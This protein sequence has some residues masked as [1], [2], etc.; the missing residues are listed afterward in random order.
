MSS[1]VGVAIVGSGIFAR[2]QH[3]PAVQETVD[4]QLKAIYSR[5][6]K[7]AQDLAQSALDTVDLYAEDAGA[8]KRYSNLLAREDIGAVIIALPILVQPEFI[9]KA[10]LAGKHVLSEK[11]IAKDLATAQDLVKWYQ[12]NVDTSTVSW[13]VA[14]NYRYFRKFLYT[15]EQVQK[16]GAVKNFRVINHT[17]VKTDFKYYQTSWRKVP[18]YQGGF[19]L[20]GGIH[21][22][23]GL[24]LILGSDDPIATLS[25]HTCLLQEYLPPKDTVD[26]ILKTKSGATGVFS[27]SY[28]SPFQDFA[29]EFD[30]EGGVVRLGMDGVLVNGDFHDVSFDG[31]GVVQEVAGF[32][33]SIANKS[34]VHKRQSPEE[35]LADLEV[36][37]LM[38]VSGEQNG[39]KK[40]LSLQV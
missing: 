39:E 38:L 16:L 21:L 10:L 14:E 13:A 35:A 27:A 9:K 32:A 7:S 22:V 37:E 4:L 19:L 36:L 12:A 1:P 30:C 20:D 28:G 15:A 18:E 24:R 29:F 40:A 2:E 33:A 6:L 17:M 3:L 34:P 5:S 23:A 31:K 8:G 25:A 11:P 26:A